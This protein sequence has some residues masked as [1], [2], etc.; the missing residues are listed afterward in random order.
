MRTNLLTLCVFIATIGCAAPSKSARPPSLGPPQHVAMDEFAW[1]VFKDRSLN[2]SFV[3]AQWDATP[4]QQLLD[5]VYETLPRGV[6]GD[7]ECGLAADRRL[8]GCRIADP[9]LSR[10]AEPIVLRLASEFRLSAEG[11]APEEV[12]YVI[13]SLRLRRGSDPVPCSAA[14]C[15]HV[16]PPPPPPPPPKADPSGPG[17]SAGGGSG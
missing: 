9:S 11:P 1:V 10:E 13:L 15:S 2:P 6:V 7:V 17:H 8:H 3:Q 16:P 12:D 4:S 14:F 5:S